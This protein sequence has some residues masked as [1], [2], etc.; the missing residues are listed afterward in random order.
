M[1]CDSNKT[2]DSRFET[3]SGLSDTAA[4]AAAAVEDDLAVVDVTDVS[5]DDE[6]GA[7]RSELSLSTLPANVFN[8]YNSSSQRCNNNITG[9]ASNMHA[10]R[11]LLV[12]SGSFVSHRPQQRRSSQL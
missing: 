11:L 8:S 10:G 4:A 3:L 9:A 1:Y 12:L 5:C 7:D 6:T 2:T